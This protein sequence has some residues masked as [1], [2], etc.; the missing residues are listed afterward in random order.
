MGKKE[1]G[2]LPPRVCG[3]ECLKLRD[4]GRA[5][6]EAEHRPGAQLNGLTVKFCQVGAFLR[7]PGRGVEVCVRLAR[8]PRERFAQRGGNL[9]TGCVA[10][11]PKG[12]L[13]TV[14]VD[15]YPWNPQ[16]VS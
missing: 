2:M 7:Q 3:C 8:P 1:P 16:G 14:G 4:E 15:L 11:G 13:E 5:T 9:A 10:H 12:V 6:S